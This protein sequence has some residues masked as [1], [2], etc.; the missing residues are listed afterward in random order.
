MI[1]M[2]KVYLNKVMED[3]CQYLTET[4]CNGLL[5]LL[6]KI[7]ELFDETLVA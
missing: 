1:N 6:Q 2:R 3:Q 7:E 5:E 4:Q